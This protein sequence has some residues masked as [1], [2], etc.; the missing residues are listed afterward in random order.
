MSATNAKDE[1]LVWLRA[2][3][4]SISLKHRGRTDLEDL[5]QNGDMHLSENQ[6]HP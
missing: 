1:W 4:W 3:Q 2:A 5:S 6:V